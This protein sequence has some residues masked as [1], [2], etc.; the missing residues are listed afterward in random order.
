MS[1]SPT[2]A[3]SAGIVTD[4]DG[5]RPCLPVAAMIAVANRIAL[6]REAAKLAQEPDG[7]AL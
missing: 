6:K 4:Y 2:L 7:G 3:K 1:I 5:K